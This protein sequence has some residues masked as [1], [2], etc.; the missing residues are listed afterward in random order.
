VCWGTRPDLAREHP[1]TAI[2][3]YDVGADFHGSPTRVF[4]KSETFEVLGVSIAGA[5][6][7]A[8]ALASSI[9]LGLGAKTLVP[10]LSRGVWGD[11]T[12]IAQGWCAGFD[13]S[14]RPNA[15]G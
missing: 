6:L 12:N 2:K 5:T 7:F 9:E 13:E 4:R 15:D 10:L 11:M 8:P 3:F 1:G 14:I